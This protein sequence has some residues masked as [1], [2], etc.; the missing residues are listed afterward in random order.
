LSIAQG[1]DGF[2]W[3]AAEDGLYRFDGLHYHKIPDLPF[4]SA[5]FVAFT[6]DGAL[7]V[8]GREGLA[9]YKDRFQV[10]LREDVD[11]MAALPDQVFVS[12][13]GLASVRLDRSVRYLKRNSRQDLTL[14]STGRLWFVCT[15]PSRACSMA[16]GQPDEEIPLPGSFYQVVRDSQGRIWAA[17]QERA[18]GLRDGKE[19]VELARRPSNK[20]GR[21]GLRPERPTL[22]PG[23]DDSRSDH[24]HRV[25]RPPDLRAVPAYGGL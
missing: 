22:V 21:P 14:D 5:R 10:V 20:T 12:A 17:T 1:P 16:E 4:S 11:G 2:L 8:A 13:A 19:L 23:G 15:A 6:G 7:W 18:V 24:R 25:P 9:H 3:L